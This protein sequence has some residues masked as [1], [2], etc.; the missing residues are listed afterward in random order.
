MIMRKWKCENTKKV[1][2]KNEMRQLQQTKKKKEK[3]KTKKWELI[4]E[5]W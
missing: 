1:L 5:D 2:K 4:N 3:R